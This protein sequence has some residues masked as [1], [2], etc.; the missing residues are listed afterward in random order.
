MRRTHVRLLLLACCACCARALA[1]EEAS[2]FASRSVATSHRCAA[3]AAAARL[4]AAPLACAAAPAC[5]L[6]R[7]AAQASAQGAMGCADW[8]HAGCSRV[9]QRGSVGAPRGARARAPGAAR[10]AAAAGGRARRRCAVRVGVRGLRRVRSRQ[11]N[12]PSAPEPR[13]TPA[14]RALHRLHAHAVHDQP[15]GASCCVAAARRRD[16][17][18]VAAAH[19]PLRPLHNTARGAWRQKR[20]DRHA[21]G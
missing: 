14:L 11:R 1:G 5:V 20:R 9:S 8:S 18:R 19:A 12:G 21:S 13:C 7:R 2:A 10:H 17:A 16:R 3:R 6:A 4:P 15:H